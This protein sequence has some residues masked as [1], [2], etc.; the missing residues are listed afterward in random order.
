MSN[1]NHYD[2]VTFFELFVFHLL[3][4][5]FLLLSLRDFNGLVGPQL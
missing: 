3:V 1:I 4:K 5:K 2:K